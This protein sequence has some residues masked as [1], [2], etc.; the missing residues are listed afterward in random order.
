MIL[1]TIPYGTITEWVCLFAS[2]L[3]IKTTKPKFWR[4]F[5]PYVAAVVFI[6]TY[7]YFLIRTSPGQVNTHWIYNIF[8]FVYLSFHLFI[9]AKIIQLKFINNLVKIVFIVLIGCYFWEWYTKGLLNF[10]AK[11]NVLFGTA[12]IILS[13]VYYYSLFYQHQIQKIFDE[14][15]FWF[16]T[17]C[18]IFYAGSTAV[19]LNIERLIELSYAKQFPF[20]RV[21][22][23]SLNV[24]MYSCWIKSFLCL[25][26]AQTYS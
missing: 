25:R 18:L 8:L 3:L 22:I 4:L 11:T 21:L 2:I 16:V 15:A 26:K 6:E 5:I 12:I 20:R 14:P 7:C 9:L 23:S 17:G 19:N 13:I 10:F 24:I 1:T